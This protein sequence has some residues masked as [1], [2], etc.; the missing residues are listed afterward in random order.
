MRLW[1]GGHELNSSKEFTAQTGSGVTNSTA[2]VRSG[3][4]AGKLDLNGQSATRN[5]FVVRFTG[6][7]NGPFFFRIYINIA[8]LPSAENRIIA[9]VNGSAVNSTPGAYITLD[10][11]GHLK[12]YADSGAVGSVSSALSLNTQYCIEIK[13]DKS[14]A[15]GSQI[16]E[17][18]LDSV[19]FATSSALT[20]TNQIQSLVWG[21][22]L[23]AEA[24]T[25]GVWYFDD[26]AINDN[27]GSYQNSYPGSGKIVHTQPNGAGDNTNWAIAGS[28]PAA[29][30]WQSV[31]EISPDDGVTTVQI[32]TPS[33]KADDYT[34]APITAIDT[35]DTINTV[36]VGGRFAAA[37]AGAGNASFC[38]RLKAVTGGTVDENT[39]FV[40]DSTSYE[41]NAHSTTL[42]GYQLVDYVKPGTSTPWSKGDLTA[43]QI[44]VREVVLNSNFCII[45]TLWMSVDY[46]PFT[47]IGKSSNS[48]LM[49]I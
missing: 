39:P 47:P 43:A 2:V 3:S 10:S 12:L 48:M 30:N 37:S 13:Y 46:T 16:L 34:V 14:Q 41:T 28:S 45:S 22:N 21:G 9:L 27:T 32:K 19:V 5:G 29:T 33:N 44:G 11:T 4:Y 40:P 25:T 15:G 6:A 17:A 36:A 49:G 23:N 7:A 18:R 42:V 31:S 1:Q 35:I 38:Y 8:T 26:I 24:Q 20:F